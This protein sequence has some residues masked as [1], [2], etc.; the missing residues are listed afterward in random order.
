M[1]KARLYI[2]EKLEEYGE[3]VLGQEQAHYVRKVLRMAPGDEIVLFDG[4]PNEYPA[5]LSEITSSVSG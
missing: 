5:T 1:Q 2:A 3:V 4:S